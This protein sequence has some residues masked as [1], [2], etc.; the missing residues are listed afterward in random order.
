VVVL[1]HF[2]SFGV[3][4]R[5][6]VTDVRYFLYYSWQVSEGAVPHLDFFENKPQLSVFLG[7]ALYRFGELVGADP[8][9]AIRA[10]QLGLA[11]LGAWLAFAVFRRLGGVAAGFV[12]LAA[13]LSFGLLG[14]LPSVGTLPKLAMVVLGTAT[15]LLVHDRR[16]VWA[17]VAG[18]LAFFDWQL[19][20]A[21]WLAA[22]AA[23]VVAGDDGR[24]RMA[25][26]GRVGLGGGIAV[27]PFA[28]YY[29]S[30][31]ALGAT[32]DQ[33]IVATFSRGASALGAKTAGDRWLRIAELVR[34][35]CPEHAWL[36]Y[37]SALGIPVAVWWLVA[38]RQREGGS[39][40]VRL[41][42]PL[43]GFH[44]ALL[45]MS[46]VE[47][48]GYGDL[49]A[50]LH[51]A[52]F[53]LGLAG[54]ALLEFV[55][56]RLGASRPWAPAALAALALIVARPGPLRPT[57]ELTSAAIGPGTTLADQREV[58][59]AAADTIGEAS[60]GAFDSSELLFLMQRRNALPSLYWNRA[61]RA[62]FRSP[63][64]GTPTETVVRLIEEAAPAYFVAPRRVGDRALVLRGSRPLVLR[65]SSGRYAVELRDRRRR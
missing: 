48:Q 41:L 40:R 36:F 53:S 25:A 16:W 2:A 34:D 43:C 59:R 3:R 31:G 64:D 47:T 30:R 38:G 19:G 44:A 29:A 21:A 56:G 4:D 18:G 1:V 13:A 6:I 54:W 24:S 65:S 32:F 23:A 10:G 42:L 8:L 50:L 61:T 35:G 60:L 63:S 33:V 28:A 15:A 37:A 49:F 58:A 57:L 11:A 17:G 5:P 55:R 26:L 62:H 14:A 27:L 52:S 7:A 20:G 9:L 12:G 46:A 22:A 39:E 45:A 51:T